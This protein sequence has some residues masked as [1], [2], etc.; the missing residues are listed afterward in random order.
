MNVLERFAAT[1]EICLSLEST[2]MHVKTLLKQ[3]GG[4][5]AAAA[6]SRAEARNT[7]R[8]GLCAGAKRTKEVAV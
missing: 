4:Y 2:A 8:S 7:I 1:G 5:I 6:Y 3:R